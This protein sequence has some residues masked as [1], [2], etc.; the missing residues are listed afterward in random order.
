MDLV[1][2]RI[3]I[4]LKIQ[5]LFIA[6]LVTAVAA[7]A[8]LSVHLW[9]RLGRLDFALRQYRAYTNG[10]VDGLKV[11]VDMLFKHFP[12]TLAQMDADLDEI[13]VETVPAAAI[14]PPPLPAV[15]ATITSIERGAEIRKVSTRP[16]GKPPRRPLS[17]PPTPRR[18]DRPGLRPQEQR[19]PFL[20]KSS[21]NPFE[22]S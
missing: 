19:G 9:K 6:F 1:I 11:K 16:L 5:L 10:D 13:L 2:T 4:D 8:A 22:D 7:L 20:G 21:D 3:L 18:L 15:A 12:P 17:E 14:P